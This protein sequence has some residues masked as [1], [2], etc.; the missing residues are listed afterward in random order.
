MHAGGV[1]MNVCPGGSQCSCVLWSEYVRVRQ[2]ILRGVAVCRVCACM[3]GGKGVGTRRRYTH[4]PRERKREKE[5]ERER[6][7]VRA[8]ARMRHAHI[9]TTVTQSDVGTIVYADNPQPP[10]THTVTHTD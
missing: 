8:R 10:H 7:C 6:V 3:G 4:S 5:K 2:S 9:H 1:S